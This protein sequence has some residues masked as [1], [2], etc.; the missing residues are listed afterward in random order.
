[1]SLRSN[2]MGET[3]VIGPESEIAKRIKN[4]T[5]TAPTVVQRRRQVF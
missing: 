1:M 5:R 3:T 4:Q 2:F